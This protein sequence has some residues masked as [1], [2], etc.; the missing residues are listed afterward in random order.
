MRGEQ[1]GDPANGYYAT[2]C[3]VLGGP[4]VNQGKVKA[5]QD[6]HCWTRTIMTL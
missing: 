2:G 6:N 3:V 4:W 1:G 5:K